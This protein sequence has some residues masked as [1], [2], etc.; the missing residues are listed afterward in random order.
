MVLLRD[1]LVG[2]KTKLSESDYNS[3]YS[4]SYAEFP[5]A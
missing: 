5:R 1:V 3:E 4:S 2:V